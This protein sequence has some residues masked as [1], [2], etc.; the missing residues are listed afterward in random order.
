MDQA[1]RS[2]RWC[3][4]IFCWEWESAIRLSL[5]DVDASSDGGSAVELGFEAITRGKFLM[6]HAGIIRRPLA[7]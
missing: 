6:F 1:V 3:E 4:A 5:L 7:V 2:R